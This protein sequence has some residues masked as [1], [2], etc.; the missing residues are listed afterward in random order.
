MAC[1]DG[2][3]AL[4]VLGGL[5]QWRA[6]ARNQKEGENKVGVFGASAPSQQSCCGLAVSVV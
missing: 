1:T 5:S 4:C 6:L 3:C 2:L